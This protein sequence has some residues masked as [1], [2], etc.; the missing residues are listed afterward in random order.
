MVMKDTF[1]FLLLFQSLWANNFG[2]L[3]DGNKGM[4]RL[5][6]IAGM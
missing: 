2:G 6:A 4:A 1:F 3:R 5:L